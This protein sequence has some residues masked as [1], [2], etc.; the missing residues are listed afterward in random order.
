M[1]YDFP[2]SNPF[3]DTLLYPTFTSA[4]IPFAF[5]VS[6]FIVSLVSASCIT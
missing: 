6:E 1:L 3:I 4:L 2:A 5:I